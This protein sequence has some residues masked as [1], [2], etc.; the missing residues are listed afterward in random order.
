MQIKQ[1]TYIIVFFLLGIVNHLK[2][3]HL[4]STTFQDCV[5]DEFALESDTVN[6]R[7]SSVDFV[8]S[9]MEQLNP[10]VKKKIKG[11][12]VFQI[13]VDKEGNSCLLSFEN[14]TNIRTKKLKFKKWIDH[15]IKWQAPTEKVSAIIS[16]KFKGNHVDYSRM[17][18]NGDK[19]WHVL[20]EP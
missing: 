20:I 2:A 15:T 5:T 17:G 18:N 19:G 12:L 1:I 7:L 13:L 14:K 10:E 8:E 4:F 6:A 16:L 11:E 3:Q 9:I